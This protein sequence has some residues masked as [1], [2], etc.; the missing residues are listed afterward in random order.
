MKPFDIRREEVPALLW[1]FAYFFCLLCAYYVLRPVRDEM[2]I[3][4][5]LGN[6][7]WLWVGTFAGMLLLTPLFGWIT[8]R[9]PRRTFLPLVYVFFIANLL[10]FFVAM[11]HPLLNQKA[12]A[13]AFFI[14]LSVFNYFVVSVFWSFMTDVFDNAAA[15]R[16]F[17]AISA[18]GSLGAM[19]G[20]IITAALVK[21]VGIPNLLLISVVFMSLAIACIVGLSRWARDGRDR[22][23]AETADNAAIGGG[24]FDGI[25]LAF[26]SPYLLAVCG[27]V[28]LLQGL[29]TYFYL[30]QIRI[31]AETVSSSV[32][33]TQL[34]AQFDLAV[35]T[36]TLLCQLFLTSTLLRKLGVVF[37]LTFL[38]ALAVVSLTV[39]GL[40]PTLAVIAV[41]GIARRTCEFA[42]G[43]PAREIL[44]TVVSREERYKSKN[45]IDTVIARGSDVVSSWGHAGLRGLGLGTSQMA[46][47]MIPLSFAMIGAGVYLGREQERR[48]AASGS[49][50]AG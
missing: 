8:S 35:N 26:K 21:Q 49:A 25:V 43:K 41:A 36:L 27:Y 50:H 40:M 14:W 37:C 38:P 30:E 44:F 15:R 34:F 33:R 31:M 5:G 28:F 20:P 1:A 10:A 3:Q 32:E 22:D 4:S 6:L 16:L 19:T 9:W 47:A 48:R 46:F 7:P 23:N 17:G 42:I 18:G 45:F 12:V 2:G 24:L 39:T 29:G 13:A 11:G